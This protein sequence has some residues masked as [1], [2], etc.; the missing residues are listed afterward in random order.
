[1]AYIDHEE[2]LARARMNR[3][4][5]PIN[6]VSSF[7]SWVFN[8]YM[9]SS[10]TSMQQGKEAEL[11]IEKQ[12]RLEKQPT[13]ITPGYELLFAD[14]LDRSNPSFKISSLTLQGKPLYGTPDVVFREKATRKV[15]IMERKATTSQPNE[16][17]NLKVQLWCYG[18]IDAWKSASRVE[19]RGSVY[20]LPK[21]GLNHAEAVGNWHRDDELFDLEC[22]ELF[23]LFGGRVIS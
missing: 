18:R 3:P 11:A 1:M 19:L 7:S 20:N 2:L 14:P 8:L 15:A 23:H 22:R 9:H 4:K 17:P 16:W 21:Y 5:A 6:T 10:Y 12:G 13:P